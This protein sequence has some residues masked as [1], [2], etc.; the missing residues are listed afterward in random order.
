MTRIGD[1]VFRPIMRA[2]DDAPVHLRGVGD[3]PRLLKR[4][5]RRNQDG[6]ADIDRTP[7][8]MPDGPVHGPDLPNPGGDGPVE[9][10]VPEGA[11]PAEIAQFHD[12]V[13]R[14]NQYLADGS[15]SG[16]GRV[17]TA[18]EISREARREARLERARALADG[19][20]Y[21]GIVAHVPDSTWVGQGKPPGW[22]DYTSR[23]NSSLAGQV[24]RYPVGHNP[25][26]FIV[27]E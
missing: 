26:I 9:F 22:G 20:P 19:N 21:Q 2:L 23:V 5:Q 16:S 10:H 1:E 11:S 27:R 17:S 6:V 4:Q 15:L 12:Y 7:D 24:N 3:V 13:N 25:T 8:G 18:G 14:S